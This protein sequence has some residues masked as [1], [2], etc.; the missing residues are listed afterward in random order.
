[1]TAL[2]FSCRVCYHFNMNAI[3]L[4]RLTAV[5]VAGIMFVSTASRCVDLPDAV[6]PA[7]LVLAGDGMPAECDGCYT[8]SKVSETCPALCVTAAGVVA[9][10]GPI[11]NML[12]RTAVAFA[13]PNGLP[14]HADPPVPRPPTQFS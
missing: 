2:D 7:D 14:G 3:T 5:V 13:V 1:M 12:A 9:D 6:M 10:D 8:P 4:R 11:L